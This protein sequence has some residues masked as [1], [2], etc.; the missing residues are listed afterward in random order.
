MKVF[1]FLSLIAS[2]VSMASTSSSISDEG[3]LTSTFVDLKPAVSL[4]G[5]ASSN[6][7]KLNT[8]TSGS[9]FKVSPSLAAEF[10]PSDSLVLNGQISGDFKKY[11]G[12]LQR[13]IG[14]ER[15]YEGRISSLYFIDEDWEFGGDIGYTDIENRIAV[16][17]SLTETGAIVQ[18]YN[19][20]DAQLF[21]ARSKDGFSVE[22]SGGGKIRRYS[23]KLEDRGNLFHND[24]DFSLGSIKIGYEFAKDFKISQKTSVENKQYKERPA[25]FTDGAASLSSAPHPVL[26]ETAKEF[27]LIGE[28]KILGVKFITTPSIRFNKDRVFGARDSE[29]KKIQQKVVLPVF[30]RVT[31]SPTITYSKEDFD[32][33]RSLPDT[34][35]LNSPLREESEWK[36]SV[37]LKVT[38]KEGIQVNADYGFTKKDSNYA[39]SSYTE[40]A[41]F[42]G[43][44]LEI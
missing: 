22:A 28:F 31:L 9:F 12:S 10:T 43:V 11:S 29:V 3:D 21:L 6:V 24:Y 7:G 2:T 14:D 18:R 40:Q 25:D 1:I 13:K 42:V 37:P 34:N 39:S 8:A 23:T 41:G 44:T 36:L 26:R 19:E 5:G 33:F 16:Q 15:T 17:T 35:P 32:R 38:L 20:P 4:S 27:S 30:P